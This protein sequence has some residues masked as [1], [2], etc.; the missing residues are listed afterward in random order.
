MFLLDSN[1]ISKFFRGDLG[2]SEKISEL[3][4]SQIMTCTPVICELL[5]GLS[6]HPNKLVSIKVRQYYQDFF[7][8]ITI[9]DLDYK[10][11]KV[12]ANIKGTLKAQGELIED[13]DLLIASIA[14][15]N[16]LVLVTNNTKNFQR[17][18]DLQVVDWSL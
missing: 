11:A 6:I 2:V 17:I 13:F 8:E 5:Y 9:K 4:N 10:S 14:I 7:E 16:D 12:F 15:A 3:D 1:I 18:P